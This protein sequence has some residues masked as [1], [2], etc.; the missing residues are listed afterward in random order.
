MDDVLISMTVVDS[1]KEEEIMGPKWQPT[2]GPIQKHV[3]WV[4]TGVNRIANEKLVPNLLNLHQKSR[5]F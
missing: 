3:A 5:D 4:T 1:K 2:G